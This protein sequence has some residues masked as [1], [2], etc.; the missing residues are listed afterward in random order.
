MFMTMT[1]RTAQPHE[2]TG[3]GN[4]NSEHANLKTLGFKVHQDFE[5]TSG[6]SQ[7]PSQMFMTMTM[8]TR[9]AQPHEVTGKGNYNSELANLKTSR[10]NVHH[11]HYTT[12]FRGIGVEH[13][14]EHMILISC[15]W[16]LNLRQDLAKVIHKCS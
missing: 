8:T 14:L 16:T 9:T 15:R 4:R 13:L 5:S 7:G 2:A 1:T 3:K 6:L 11:S 12:V 10:F